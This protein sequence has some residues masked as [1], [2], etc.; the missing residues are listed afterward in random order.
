MTGIKRYVNY[1]VNS[2]KIP[3]QFINNIIIPLLHNA[4]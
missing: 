4:S 1:F 3:E 2:L